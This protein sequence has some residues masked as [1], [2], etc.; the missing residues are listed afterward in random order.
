MRYRSDCEMA[1]AP[2]SPIV[3]P[4]RSR[5]VRQIFSLTNKTHDNTGTETNNNKKIDSNVSKTK[6]RSA[7]AMASAPTLPILLCDRDSSFMSVFTLIQHNTSIMEYLLTTHSINH[8]ADHE[9]D[10]GLQHHLF[11]NLSSPTIHSAAVI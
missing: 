7:S 11:H 9:L 8:T 10:S 5:I 6:Y 3:F 1:I 4:D 2:A